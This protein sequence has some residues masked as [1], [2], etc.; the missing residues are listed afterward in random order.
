MKAK[1]KIEILTDYYLELKGW[2]DQPKRFYKE[3]GISYPRNLK[4]SKQILLLC[5]G[6]LETARQKV[7][8][9]KEWAEGNGLEWTLE[10]CIKKFLDLNERN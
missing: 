9:T 7:D 8:K 10:T 2:N 4:V 5:D 1:N 3:N 6:S